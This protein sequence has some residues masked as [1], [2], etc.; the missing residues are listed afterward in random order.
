M[1]EVRLWGCHQEQAAQKQHWQSDLTQEGS[2]VDFWEDWERRKSQCK[3]EMGQ[4]AVKGPVRLEGARGRVG[5]DG[6]E[7][8]GGIG[9]VQGLVPPLSRPLPER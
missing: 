2:H 4:G 6:R 3:V 7:V 9:H 1:S 5:G 8:T